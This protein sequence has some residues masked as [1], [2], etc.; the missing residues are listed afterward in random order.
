MDDAWRPRPGSSTLS[1]SVRPSVWSA[2]CV[3]SER[4]GLAVADG[5][6]SLQSS[7]QVPFSQYAT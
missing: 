4:R 2:P 1:N 3:S 7:V 6:R 5:K